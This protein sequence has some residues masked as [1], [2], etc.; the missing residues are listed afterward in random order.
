MCPH[1]LI[2]DTAKVQIDRSNPV[3][4][5]G[6]KCIPIRYRVVAH[7]N[8]LQI[9]QPDYEGVYYY[10]YVNDSSLVNTSIRPSHFSETYYTPHDKL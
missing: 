1:L 2:R 5:K 8:K 7:P 9:T 10:M 6:K 3:T 4:I